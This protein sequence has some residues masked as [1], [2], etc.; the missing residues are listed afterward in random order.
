MNEDFI[1]IF[2]VFSNAKKH[3]MYNAG[4]PIWITLVERRSPEY[5]D[6]D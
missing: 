4:K 2:S 6:I 5:F 1:C 3:T